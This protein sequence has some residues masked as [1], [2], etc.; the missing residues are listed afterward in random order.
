MRKKDYI[1]HHS[2]RSHDPVV[3]ASVTYKR[4]FDFLDEIEDDL[5]KLISQGSFI[6]DLYGCNGNSNRFF[7]G[8]FRD[9]KIDHA[10]IISI[11]PEA[12]K[13]RVL[14]DCDRLYDKIKPQITT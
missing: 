8:Y 14:F 2:G 6:F 10:E 1:I 13:E 11:S 7:A 3:V 9:G 4:L 5:K 12:I